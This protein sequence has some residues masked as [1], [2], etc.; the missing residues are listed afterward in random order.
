MEFSDYEGIS[1]NVYLSSLCY[2]SLSHT[3]MSGRK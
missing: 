3:T 1:L 2:M